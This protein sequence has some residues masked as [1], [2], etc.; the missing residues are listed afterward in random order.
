M[1]VDSGNT[2]TDILVE[3]PTPSDR[4]RKSRSA[5]TGYFLKRP[6]DV[7]VAVPLALL[8]T[9]LILVLMLVSAVRFRAW[10][11]FVQGR[12]GW[13]GHQFPLYKIRSL[14]SGTPEYADREELTDVEICRWGRFIRN[15]H[16]DEL[17]Q[18]WQVVTGHLALVGPRP[19]IDSIVDRMHPDHQT[20]RH[21]VRPG[22][23]GLWQV[24]EAGERLVLEAAE[25]DQ[26]Y[27]EFASLK[28]DTWIIWE[29][30]KQILG[31][32]PLAPTDMP[33]WVKILPAADADG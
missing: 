21:S 4:R 25:Y 9:P 29:T 5:S 31:A 8:T 6:L 7:L 28:L 15:H 22:V 16:L 17:P 23:T 26:H 30:V 20:H 11:L 19:M 12:V 1:M 18:L 32:R 14:P 27:V 24:S 33:G 13:N 10:P 2:T 3:S